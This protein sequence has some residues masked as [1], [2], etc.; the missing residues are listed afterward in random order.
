MASRLGILLEQGR[1]LGILLGQMR[2]TVALSETS[3][4]ATMAATEELSGARH[5]NSSH[6][7]RNFSVYGNLLSASP[8]ELLVPRRGCDVFFG[9]IH[10]IQS[11]L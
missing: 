4:P 3:K 7:L 9:S 8:D 10:P 1:Y 5:W 11:L 2:G 6:A